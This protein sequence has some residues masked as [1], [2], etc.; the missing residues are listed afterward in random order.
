MSEIAVIN[1]NF[2]FAH[3]CILHHCLK[4]SVIVLLSWYKIPWPKAVTSDFTE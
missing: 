2:N 4:L 3:A 1:D